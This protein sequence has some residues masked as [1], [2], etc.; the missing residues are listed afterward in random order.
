MRVW[1]RFTGIRLSSGWG[2]FIRLH[3]TAKSDYLL[4]HVCSVCLSVRTSFRPHGRARLPLDGFSW[5]FTFEY[6]FFGNLARKLKVIK[7]LTRWRIL[8]MR[9]FMTIS[10]WI[11]L[12]M[13]NVSD[14]SFRQN[15]N[16]TLYV[17]LLS[18]GNRAV[19]EIMCTNIVESDNPQMTL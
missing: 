19:C 4:C 17:P 3:G 5:N 1:T 9:K 10:L 11:L 12:R 13:R 15:K 8:Y 7:I 2:F 14:K 18:S 16:T 6:F